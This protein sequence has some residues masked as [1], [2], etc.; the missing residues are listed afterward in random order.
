MEQNLQSN[1]NKM[2]SMRD[3]IPQLQVSAPIKDFFP[4]PPP[5]RQSDAK[6]S[7]PLSKL[8]PLTILD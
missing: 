4:Q 5:S 8:A 3:S 2:I 1:I 6:F 7:Q